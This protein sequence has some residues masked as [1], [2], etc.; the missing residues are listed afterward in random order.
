MGEMTGP[1]EA[2]MTFR[3]VANVNIPQVWAGLAHLFLEDLCKAN[4]NSTDRK[5]L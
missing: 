5:Q 1:S 3:E 4:E 2:R